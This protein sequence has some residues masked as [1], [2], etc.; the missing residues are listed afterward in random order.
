MPET[1]SGTDK[2]PLLVEAVH[3]THLARQRWTPQPTFL[4]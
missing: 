4:N 1:A 2:M 3:P